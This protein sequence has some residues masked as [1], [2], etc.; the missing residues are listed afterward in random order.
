MYLRIFPEGDEETPNEGGLRFYDDLFD[1]C[2]KSGIEP[3]VTISH[4]ETP[5]GLAKKY[6]GY[7]LPLI[8][9]ENGLGAVD[10]LVT[11]ENG[12]KTVED[13]YRIDYLRQQLLQV[14]EAIRDGVELWGYT[15]WGC[16]DLV[17]ASTA[18]MKKRYGYI[19]VDRN[20]DGRGSLERYRKKSFLSFL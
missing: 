9:V 20:D 18:E 2:R 11:L 1:E 6:D 4:Y 15:S 7:Q 13:D 10:E 3:M 16:I 14:R 12:E 19:Y 17:S 5:L 8:I